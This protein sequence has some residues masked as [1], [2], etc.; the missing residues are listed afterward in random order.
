M[1]HAGGGPCRYRCQ[2]HSGAV[3]KIEHAGDAEDQREAGRPKGIQRTDGKA[4]D[5]DPES[6]HLLCPRQ[7]RCLTLEK[8]AYAK[9]LPGNTP[10]SMIYEIQ[11]EV[12]LMKLGN[13]NWPLATSLR[14]TLA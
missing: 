12:S 1:Q 3:R 5:Q 13:F 6:K 8:T 11:F 4:V 7:H 9:M 14:P 10:G 2:H